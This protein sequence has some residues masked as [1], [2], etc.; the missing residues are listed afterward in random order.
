MQFRV[1]LPPRLCKPNGPQ[2]NWQAKAKAKASYREECG[3][4]AICERNALTVR[5][6][7]AIFQ[8]A[9]IQYTIIRK[10]Q[11]GRY[12]PRDDDNAIAALKAAQD[13]FKDARLFADDAHGQ[14]TVLPPKWRKPLKGEAGGIIVEIKEREALEESGKPE[15]PQEPR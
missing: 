6:K 12:L 8:H 14:V 5:A 9:V 1:N 7:G 4:R 11:E 10:R 13:G 15:Q 2:G 3:W